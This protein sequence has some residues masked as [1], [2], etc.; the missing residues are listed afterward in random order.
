[1]TRR[2]KEKKASLDAL[3]RIAYS[4][5]PPPPAP[6]RGAPS[7]PRPSPAAPPKPRPAPKPASM[8]TEADR[9]RRRQMEERRAKLEEE[10]ALKARREG[11]LAR[12]Q[13]LPWRGMGFNDIPAGVR[14]TAYDREEPHLGQKIQDV[15]G[16]AR[17]KESRE[18]HR[19]KSRRSGG[20]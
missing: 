13:N 4:S 19:E 5:A 8:E 14:R 10:R 20:R 17:Q 2:E 11:E 12:S 7:A 18:Q 16:E 6:P 9:V 1:M 3:A 15:L